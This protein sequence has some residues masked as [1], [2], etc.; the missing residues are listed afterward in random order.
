MKKFYLLITGFLFFAIAAHSQYSKYIV[1]FTNKKGTP[2]SLSNPATYLS[3]KAVERRTRYNINIDSTDLPVSPAYI[4]SIRNVPNVSIHNISKW[5]NQV[6]II[7]TDAAA[8]SKINSFP[9]VKKTDAIAAVSYPNDPGP[10]SKKFSSFNP[11]DIMPAPVISGAT[12][13]QQDFYDYGNN[14]GQVRIH[15]GEYLHN[16][17]FHGEGITI[18]VL[19]GGFLN[20]KTNIALDSARINNQILGEWDFVK[21]ESS[22]NEDHPHGFWCLSVI[23]TNRPGVMVGTA[24]KA[25]FWLFR[26]ED[27]ASE[28]PVEEQNWAVAAEFA[29]SAGV[30]IISS[31]LGY[32]DFNDPVFNHSYAQRNGNTAISTIAADLAAKKG[33]LVT[34]S[35]GNSGTN[36]SD[37]K[38]TICPADADSV[39]CVGATDV[40][41][42]IANFSSW[43]PNGAGK[44][45]P[46]VVSVGANAV[47]ASSISGNP[48]VLSGTSFSNPNMCGLTACLWQAFPEFNNMEIIS[49][50]QESAHKFNN[51]DDRFGYGIPNMRKAY[52]ILEGK[53]AIRD[54]QRTLGNQWIKAFPVPFQ[55]QL[56]ILLKAPLTGKANLRLVDI[57]GRIIELKTVE[58]V[59]DN[60]YTIAFG[61]LN[62]LGAGVYSIQYADGKNKAT[63][64]AVK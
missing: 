20:F 13:T 52:E 30:D 54:L 9:F 17:G 60:Y 8:L 27:V 62:T 40:N 25:K 35:A 48:A 41:G 37:L 29:D 61:K 44:T 3:S 47:V 22:T 14:A 59:Q 32:S 56:T 15:E 51:P 19:D 26:T 63:L 7:T 11:V 1:Q 46:N 34:N 49:A 43:G 57:S 24:P 53:R 58:I 12:G 64:R 5:L 4:D 38:F 2:H 31:S 6:C 33:I 42:V 10:V 23:A 28:Y 18:A 55:S 39:L 45:K 36:S 16:K 50:L 21:N